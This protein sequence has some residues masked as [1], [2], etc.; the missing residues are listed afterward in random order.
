MQF[1]VNNEFGYIPSSVFHTQT[2][3]NPV[4]DLFL[5]EPVYHQPRTHFHFATV[6]PS[7]QFAQ[8][9]DSPYKV[10]PAIRT[11]ILDSQNFVQNQVGRDG[12]I[13]YT[14]RIII[15]ISTRFG[16]QAIPFAIQI[17]RKVMQRIGFINLFTFPR[18]VRNS[19]GVKPLRSFTTRL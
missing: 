13:Q 10:D 16:C 18:A 19:A 12:H 6:N 9:A 7:A 8:A 5:F 15:V 3:L 17:E 14:Y 11:Q 4:S 2:L 1:V